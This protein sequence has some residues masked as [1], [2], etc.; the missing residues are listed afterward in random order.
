MGRQTAADVV[1]AGGSA[2]II[3]QEPDKVAIP[4]RSSRSRALPT[5]SRRTCRTGWRRRGCAG[6]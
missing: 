5:G 1:A 3:G 2:V 4:S 6:S